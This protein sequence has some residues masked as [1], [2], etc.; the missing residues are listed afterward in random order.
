MNVTVTQRDIDKAS[1]ILNCP[2]P[3][4]LRSCNCPVA[5]AIKRQQK[6]KVIVSGIWMRILCGKD[7]Y[8]KSKHYSLPQKARDFILSFDN[9]QEVKPFR[10]SVKIDKKL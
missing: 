2:N 6:K 1:R 8:D 4:P 3:D 5:Q 9:N 10:F 7:A